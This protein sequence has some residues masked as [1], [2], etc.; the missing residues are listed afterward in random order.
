MTPQPVSIDQF[1]RDFQ[2]TIADA[3]SRLQAISP[4]QSQTVRAAGHWTQRQILG[5]LIDSVANNHQRFVRAQFSDDLVFPGYQQEDWVEVQ[6]YN[7]ESWSELIKLWASYNRHLAH[8]VSVI[9]ADIMTK[10]RVEHNLDQIAFRAV[11]K[12]EPA[13]LEYFIRD[14]V[15]H[16]QHH[17]RQ[18][19]SDN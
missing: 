10:A 4:Q 2:H 11:P 7:D 1:L 6:K 13:T 8:A 15:D 14:Y 9:P 16:L 3:E 5:H 12:D 17:L 18:I 19:F